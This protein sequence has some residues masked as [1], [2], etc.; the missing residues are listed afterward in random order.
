MAAGRAISTPQLTFAGEIGALHLVDL[1]FNNT[2]RIAVPIV[3]GL[4]DIPISFNWSPDGSQLAFTL[5][6]S[7]QYNLY[8]VDLSSRETRLLLS[9]L[10]ISAPPSWSPDSRGFVYAASALDICIYI[11]A[12][13]RSHCLGTDGESLASP[14]WSPDGSTIAFTGF[15]Q[16]YTATLDQ[17]MRGEYRPQSVLPP[18]VRSLAWSPSGERLAFT[19]EPGA[20]DVRHVFLLETTTA[21]TPALRNL[22]APTA[23]YRSGLSWAPDASRL[24]YN[25]QFG[26]VFDVYLYDFGTQTEIN[27]TTDVAFEGGA[28]WSQDGQQLAYISDRSGS[29]AVYVQ[30]ARADAQ[31]V[32]V[33]RAVSY[34]VAWRPQQ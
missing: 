31:P 8:L 18:L 25:M 13:A 3:D 32:R 28:A 19:A 17:F 24:V 30:R 15:R 11:L 34:S 22:T 14:Q 12:N 6:N 29:P 23:A 21:D 1:G 5:L 10:P 4:G 27:L 9:G 33:G 2:V 26:R 16:L 20:V 7:G